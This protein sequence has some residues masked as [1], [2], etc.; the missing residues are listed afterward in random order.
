MVVSHPDKVATSNT[1][2]IF[3]MIEYRLEFEVVGNSRYQRT[4][5][6]ELLRR[7]RHGLACRLPI[8]ALREVDAERI[9]SRVDIVYRN[10]EVILSLSSI[11]PT[12][13]PV[14][15]NR[16]IQPMIVGYSEIVSRTSADIRNCVTLYHDPIG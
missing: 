8:S 7:R 3:F 9:F 4:D 12:P 15:R 14:K 1:N 13:Y 6:R 10:N 11:A 5:H 2:I 16:Y